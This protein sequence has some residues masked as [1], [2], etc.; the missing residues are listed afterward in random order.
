M[1]FLAVSLIFFGVSILF[2]TITMIIWWKKYG[3]QVFLTLKK[4][5]LGQNGPFLPPN[6]P[7]Y[8]KFDKQIKNFYE[9]M[10]KMGK[11]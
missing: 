5:F 8:M 2:F 7:N 4:G 6:M 3:K 9:I 1:T 10:N 11:K